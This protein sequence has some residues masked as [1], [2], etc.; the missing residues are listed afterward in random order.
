MTINILKRLSRNQAV[1]KLDKFVLT[2]GFPNVP[3]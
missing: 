1:K 2:Q 3:E